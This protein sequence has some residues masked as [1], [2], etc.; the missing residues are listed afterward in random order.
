MAFALQKNLPLLGNLGR[1]SPESVGNDPKFR[2]VGAS[3]SLPRVSESGPVIEGEPVD[4]TFLFTDIEGS[5]GLWERHPTEMVAVIGRHDA[6]LEQAIADNKGVLIGKTGDGVVGGF[7]STHDALAA[8]VVSQRA[9]LTENWGS[10]PEL[11]V[12]MGIHAGPVFRRGDEYHGRGLNLSSRLHAAGHGGQILVSDV[13]AHLLDDQ[14]PAPLELTDLG[15]HRLRDF[16]EPIRIHQVGGPGLPAEFPRLRSKETGPAPLPAPPSRPIGRDTEI[17]QLG[18]LIGDHAL[19]TV[20]G[21]PGVGKSRLAIDV[22]NLRR[23][24]YANGA[25]LCG[26]AGVAADDIPV[27]IAAALDVEPRADVDILSAIVD[28]TN[29]LEVLLVVDNCE[30]DA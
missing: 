26:L 16:A 13:A 3:C 4:L 21:S 23:D 5:T 1:Y 8:A 22:A 24:G 30:H 29:N 9:L 15:M 18:R 27:A 11:L 6:I 7:A 19:I 12:R 17:V 28:A 2:G 25:R 20:I 14:V 10:I